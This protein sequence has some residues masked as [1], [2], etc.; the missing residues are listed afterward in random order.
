MERGGEEGGRGGKKGGEE[1]RG[2]TRRNEEGRGAKRRE[3]EKDEE[4]CGNV[5]MRMYI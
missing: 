1:G 2:G 3:R 4:E 5:C